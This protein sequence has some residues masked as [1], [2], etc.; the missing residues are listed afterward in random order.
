M[1][2]VHNITMQGIW[3]TPEILALLIIAGWII[4]MIIVFSIIPYFRNKTNKS[5]SIIKNNKRKLPSIE[6]LNFYNSINFEEKKKL[7]ELLIKESIDEY[8]LLNLAYKDNLYITEDMEREMI[9]GVLER[10]WNR[11]SIAVKENIYFL[12]N[13]ENDDELMSLL[14]TEVALRVVEFKVNINK[15]TE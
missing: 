1:N 3:H 8:V 11:M 7:L 10:L 2:M 14:A 15:P 5:R 6:E 13:A 4:L 12:Y 9:R